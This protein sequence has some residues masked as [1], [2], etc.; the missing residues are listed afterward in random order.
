MLRPLVQYILPHQTDNAAAPVAMGTG[1]R[2]ATDE[3]TPFCDEWRNLFAVLHCFVTA[4][5]V[6]AG[7]TKVT[8]LLKRTI[9]LLTPLN[10]SSHSHKF[11]TVTVK[12]IIKRESLYLLT[13]WGVCNSVMSDDVILWNALSRTRFYV[14]FFITH[15]TK[16]W[17]PTL[18]LHLFAFLS[19]QYKPGSH[20]ART[21]MIIIRRLSLQ[22]LR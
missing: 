2:A 4:V 22:S 3:I 16:H 13:T 5:W 21:L 6:C 1:P 19:P 11:C 7:V 18:Q 8:S 9:M 17:Q 15:T 12:W 10:K 14:Y 20:L